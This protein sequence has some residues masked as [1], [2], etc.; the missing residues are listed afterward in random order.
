MK[1]ILILFI[2][3]LPIMAIA[4]TDTTDV[5]VIINGVK[6]ATRNVDKPGT[7]TKNPEDRGM[8]YQWNSIT[9]WSS[10]DPIIST[11]GSEWKS[12][13]RGNDAFLW[14]KVNDPCPKDWRMPTRAEFDKLVAAGSVWQYNGRL[15]ADKLFLPAAGS[16][17]GSKGE[18]LRN[19]RQM[20]YYWSSTK[21]GRDYSRYLIFN[22]KSSWVT[23]DGYRSHSFSCRCVYDSLSLTVAETEMVMEQTPEGENDPLIYDKGIIINGVKWATRNVDKPGTF[24]ATPEEAGMFYQWNSKTGWSTTDS[25]FSTDGTKTWNAKWNGNNAVAWEKANDP[26]PE[27]WRMP[28]YEEFDKLVASGSIGEKNGQLFAGKLFLRGAG[29]LYSG[30]GMLWS[31]GVGHYWSSTTELLGNPHDLFIRNSERGAAVGQNNRANGFL[32]RCVAE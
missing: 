27:G 25:L 32:C 7:F 12:S 9:G 10:R 8:F 11:D 5:G 17:F 29:T 6:W 19:V 3:L 4:Q 20:G 2:V 14:E 15:F 28:T 18:N 22:N 16:R 24:A 13:W 30:T 23:S 1:N 26:C 21:A 31:E